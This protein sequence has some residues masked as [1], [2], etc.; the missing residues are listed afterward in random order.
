MRDNPLLMRPSRRTSRSSPRRRDHVHADASPAGREPGWGDALHPRP[1]A[2]SA[3]P[4][5]QSNRSERIMP[6][7]P[8]S[9]SRSSQRLVSINRPSQ[10]FICIF[11]IY[12][13]LLCTFAKA[14]WSEEDRKTVLTVIISAMFSKGFMEE[15]LKP[16]GLYSHRAM[17]TLL[18]RLAHASIMRLNAASMDRLYELVVMAFKYQVLLCPRPRD[19]LLITFNHTD[20]IRNF[21][22]HSPATVNQVD[23][24]QRR[25]IETYTRLSEGEFQLIRQTLLTFLQDM[26]VRVSLFLKDKLQNPSGRFV[27]VTTGPV[28]HASDVPGLI[29][30]FNRKGREVKRREFPAGGS[31]T[32]PMREGSFEMFGDRAT[33]LGTNMYSVTPVADGKTSGASMNPSQ[34]PKGTAEP[35]PMAKE[36]LN[37][38][39]RLMGGVEGQGNL[40]GDGAFQVNLFIAGQEEDGTG[41]P[42]EVEGEPFG[43]INIQATTDQLASTELARIAGEFAEDGERPD[44]PSSKG[45]DL[46]AMMDDL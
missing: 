36:E 22:K 7:S 4:F 44:E 20:A 18:T 26:H 14:L 35:N 46:L 45:E 38:L 31:Y 9:R 43:V 1:A 16:Q 37:L 30:I 8:P 23:E 15:L 29:R 34:H 33:R 17:R 28:P 27:L 10:A 42:G 5:R 13:F 12:F 21:V 40:S 39:A 19:L 32:S 24:V 25:L 2:P 41:A 11:Y 6:P 3:G